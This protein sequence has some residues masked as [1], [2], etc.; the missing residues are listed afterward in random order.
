LFLVQEAIDKGGFM[1]SA[2]R[3]QFISVALIIFI[4]IW[5]TGFD[6]VHWFLYVPVGALALA[7]ITGICP[8]LIMLKKIGLK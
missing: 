3:V 1:S 7:G 4:G 2:L 5:L 6:K 8:G